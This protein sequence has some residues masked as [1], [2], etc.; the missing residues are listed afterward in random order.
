MVTPM[1]RAFA[2]SQTIKNAFQEFLKEDG[3]ACGRGYKR[4]WNS[5]LYDVFKEFTEAEITIFIVE[6]LHTCELTGKERSDLL[7]ILSLSQTALTTE[8]AAQLQA[9]LDE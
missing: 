9:T 5:I 3:A 7:R 4:V 8:Q 1:Q 2:K 6:A